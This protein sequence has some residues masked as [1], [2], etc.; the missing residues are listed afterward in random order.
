VDLFSGGQLRRLTIFVGIMPS[1]RLDL[2]RCDR[3]Y[4][5][6]AKLQKEANWGAKDHAVDAIHP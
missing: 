1:S 3:V 2:L 4:E 6:L 5:P